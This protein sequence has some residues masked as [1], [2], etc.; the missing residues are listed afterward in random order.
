M[1]RHCDGEVAVALRFGKD[2][3]LPFLGGTVEAELELECQCCLEPL[4]LRVSSEFRL[5]LVDS[6]EA[7][8][9]LPEQYEPLLVEG[10]QLAIADIVQDELL[11]AIPYCPQHEQC[12]ALVQQNPPATAE[13]EN[14]FGILADLIK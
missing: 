2:G 9:R 5:G 11:L 14:P 3:R 12:R 6:L 8:G 13:R 4:P 10:D 1:L 7:A